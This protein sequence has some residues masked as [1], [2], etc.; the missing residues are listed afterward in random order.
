MAYRSLVFRNQAT[1]NATNARSLL[2]DYGEQ[3][4]IDRL[5]LAACIDSKAS[6]PRIQQSLREGQAVGVQST[7]TT[8]INGRMVV[9][10]PSPD[11][12]FKVINEALHLVR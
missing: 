6:L 2:I 9:G 8:F 11:A 12:V 1:F 3:A 10:L 4:G 7:P 5:Q